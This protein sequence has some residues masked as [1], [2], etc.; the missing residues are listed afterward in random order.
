[1]A[2]IYREEQR[3]S[4][5]AYRCDEGRETIAVGET[6]VRWFQIW[7]GDAVSGHLCLTCRDMRAIA[8]DVFDWWEEC[9]PGLGE[10]RSFL[11][12]EEGVADPDAWLAARLTE[13]LAAKAERVLVTSAAALLQCAL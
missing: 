12:S 6:Y 5:K 9:A 8:W 3:R 2:D 4:R 11:R 7:E 10:L 1:M 13:R